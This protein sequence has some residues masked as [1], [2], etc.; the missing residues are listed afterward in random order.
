MS[1]KNSAKI[2]PETH[3][4]TNTYDRNIS[5]VR[6]SFDLMSVDYQQR[7]GKL[8]YDIFVEREGWVLPLADHADRVELDEFDC[9]HT[10]YSIAIDTANRLSGCV[11]A[12]PLH[13]GS[14][15]TNHFPWLAKISDLQRDGIYEIS[16]FGMRRNLGNAGRLLLRSVF[17]TV[18]NLGASSAVAVTTPQIERYC[19][20]IGINSS[21]LGPTCEYQGLLVVA[22]IFDINQFSNIASIEK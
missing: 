17:E 7:L 6:T 5:V 22:L 13:I 2:K 15:L 4:L 14:V 21:R 10:Y 16:R 11:R 12:T 3:C 20:L 8:R 18:Y 9:T 19:N 1:W